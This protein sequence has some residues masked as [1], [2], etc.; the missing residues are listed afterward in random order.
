MHEQVAAL[1]SAREWRGDSPWLASD[2][3]NGLF[4]MEFLR[5]Q[6]AADGEGLSAAGFIKLAGDELDALILTLFVRDLSAEYGVRTVLR[7]EDNPIAKLRYLEFRHGRLPSGNSLEEMFARR[8][9]IKKVM[10]QAIMFYPPAHRL[11]THAP[12]RPA[13]WGYGLCGLR[14]YA[15]TLLEAEREALKILRAMR[16]LGR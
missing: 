7:D 14:A 13:Q 3:S 1:A 9:V 12:A 4:E 2:R 5:H 8:P 6:R 15:P 16:H 10:G 11:N